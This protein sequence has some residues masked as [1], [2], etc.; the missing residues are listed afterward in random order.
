M[1]YRE[2][3]RS[4]RRQLEMRLFININGKQVRTKCKS[5]TEKS[6]DLGNARY[7]D[8]VVIGAGQD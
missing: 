2:Y 3:N 1:R 7:R 5:I 4:N 8:F 6:R